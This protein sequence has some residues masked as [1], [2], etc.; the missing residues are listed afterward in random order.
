MVFQFRFE[1]QTK[2]KDFYELT[3]GP[4]AQV[5]KSRVNAGLCHLY[6]QCRRYSTDYSCTSLF[7][8]SGT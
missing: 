7:R 6:G 2:P 1:V 3:A 8:R 5:V 4:Q